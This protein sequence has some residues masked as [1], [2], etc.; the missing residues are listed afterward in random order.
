MGDLVLPSAARCLDRQR[1]ARP[2]EVLRERLQIAREI[3][4]RAVAVVRVLR[5]TTF[6]DPSQRHGGAGA[7]GEDRFGRGVEDRGERADRCVFPERMAPGRHLVE[8][9]AEGELIGAEVDVGAAR[10][11][12]RHVANGSEHDALPRVDHGRGRELLSSSAADPAISRRRNRES[13]PASRRVTITF[14][15]EIAM[16]RSWHEP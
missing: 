13:S 3:A 9:D 2:G 15:A 11:F 10:L 7:V 16:E 4:R 12:R 8:Q 5:Q 6:D 14:S 1:A